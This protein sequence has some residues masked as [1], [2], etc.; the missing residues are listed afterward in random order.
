MSEPR[1]EAQHDD[2]AAAEAGGG[3]RRTWW[4]VGLVAALAVVMIAAIWASSDPD[5]LERIA[6][7]L[8]FIDAGEEPGFEILPDYTV[9][10]MDGE[11]STIVAGVIG[12]IVVLAVVLL[13]GRLLARRSA[14]RE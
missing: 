9:P 1:M 7:D 2:H 14:T 3:S 12:I 6:E 5:G 10:G 13:V 8:G 4:I 11:L